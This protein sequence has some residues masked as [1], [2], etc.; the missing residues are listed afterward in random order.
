M[1]I[2]TIALIGATGLIGSH[3]ARNLKDKGYLL[4]IFG[5][6]IEKSKRIIPFADEYYQW[7]YK[8]PD[9]LAINLDGAD[10]VIHLSGAN[11]FAKRWTEKFKKEI[12]DSRIDST[13]NVVE[14]FKKLNKKPELFI[15]SSGSNY[16]GSRGD[17]PLTE[18]SSAGND[19]M[20]DVCKGWESEASKAEELGIRR[21]SIR[22]SVVFSKK[23]S[24]LDQMTLPYKLFVGGPLANGKQFM[25]WIHIEDFESI[26]NFIIENKNI[27][28]A[29]NA[30]APENITMNVMAIE[31]GKALHRPSFFRVPKFVLKIILGE[32]ANVI[33]GSQKIIPKKLLDNNFIFKYPI[34]EKALNDLLK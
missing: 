17:E 31:F 4:K 3:L 1:Y 20:A 16:Y 13:R 21:A 33:T 5:G 8:N 26:I 30:G 27:T 12:Y 18:S 9:T 2:K 6:S 11:V 19:F 25:P 22:T 14:A 15:C 24:A 23:G 28:G 7:N 34:L 29:V 32:Y 10:I